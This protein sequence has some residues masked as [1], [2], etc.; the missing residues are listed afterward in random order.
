MRSPITPLPAPQ[1]VGAELEPI[2]EAAIGRLQAG[3]TI[4]V[5]ALVAVYPQHAAQLR[6]LLPTIESLLNL[7]R[8]RTALQNN[9]TEPGAMARPM[10]LGDFR[11][12]A[13]LGA[14]EWELFMKRSSCRWADASHSR[15][16][17]LRPSPTTSR[18]SDFAMK[19]ARRRRLIILTLFPCTRSVR[20]AAS[21]T[22]PC[23]WYA[24]KA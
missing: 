11:I 10:Q 7:G 6:E 23:N 21:T 9:S 20:S 19:S 16:C 13:R 14:G 1:T 22:M 15:S 12:V 18:Y 3:E 17:H 24:A 4:D 8:G 5:E 2:I